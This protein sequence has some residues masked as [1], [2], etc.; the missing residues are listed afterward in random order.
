[1]LFL[2]PTAISTWVPVAGVS[3]IVSVAVR[4]SRT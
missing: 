4:P 1:M 2:S 3:V